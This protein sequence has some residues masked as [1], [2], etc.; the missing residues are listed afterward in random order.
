MTLTKSNGI[1]LLCAKGE[2][3]NEQ[4]TGER[5]ELFF[6]IFV[7]FFNAVRLLDIDLIVT[8]SVVTRTNNRNYYDLLLT[9]FAFRIN[10]ICMYVSVIMKV[11]QVKKFSFRKIYL[12]KR[13]LTLNGHWGSVGPHKSLE[14]NIFTSTSY[15]CTLYVECRN[16]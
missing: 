11:V 7:L 13:F 15:V 9:F 3:K 10:Y 5:T 6:V 8:T 12:F 2:H 14:L 1:Y 4:R 16:E